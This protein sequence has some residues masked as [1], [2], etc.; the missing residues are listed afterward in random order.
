MR[1]WGACGGSSILPSPTMEPETE[2]L[3]KTWLKIQIWQF[4]L[5]VARWALVLIFV[6]G[7][8]FGFFKFVLPAFRA[9][10]KKLDKIQ[11]QLLN[12]SEKTENQ[13]GLFEQLEKGV[14]GQKSA[15]DMFLK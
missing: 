10:A 5:S 7:G 11:S 12:L 14:G 15:L 2:K 3:L 13:G 8:I 9:E 4:W 6:F 1:A